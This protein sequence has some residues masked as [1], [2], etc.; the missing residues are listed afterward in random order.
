MKNLIWVFMLVAIFFAFY[1]QSKPNPNILIQVVCIAVFMFGLMRKMSKI[2]SKK[3][4]N[5][6]SFL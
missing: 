4:E 3:D 5:D 2:P 6:N 1:E